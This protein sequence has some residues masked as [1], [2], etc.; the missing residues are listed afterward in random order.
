MSS[1]LLVATGDNHLSQHSARMAPP[2]LERRRQRLRQAFAASAEHAVQRGADLFIVAGDLFDSPSPSN[3][4]LAAVARVFRSLT[5][6]GVAVC[7]VGGNHDTPG[8]RTVHGGQG[9]LAPLAVLGD[10]T[11]F[12]EPSL[13]TRTLTLRGRSVTIG[14]LTPL[15]G[16]TR[17]DP[18]A[19]LLADDAPQVEIFITHAAIE[20]HSYSDAAE[21]VLLKSTARRVPWLRLAVAGHVHRFAAVRAG[22][23]FLLSPGST[24]W[25]KHGEDSHAAGFAT[26][27]LGV[28]GVE[29]IEHASL[30]PQP[31]KTL[32]ISVDSLTEEPQRAL[33]A[34][35]ADASDPE[36][37]LRVVLRGA[38]PRSRFAELRLRD[39]QSMGAERNF[40]FALQ[41]ED[42]RVSD[43]PQR[44]TRRG[45]RVSHDEEVFA[46]AAE[47]AGAASDE[48]SAAWTEAR[49]DLLR[50]LR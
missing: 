26:V 18:L 34:A 29:S 31:R 32:E 42:L 46:A 33:E 47:L 28:A 36:L 37:L 12:A 5:Q 8:S 23:C 2:R 10:V 15:P 14:G 25:M 45:V 49:D 6:A 11:Y 41:T 13:Q 4:D 35:I 39:L 43:D 40:H 38:L 17:S 9:P 19:A 21:P 20:G 16:S 3:A 27:T 7:A 22:N 48:D 50:R 30:S 1:L 24:E 44:S